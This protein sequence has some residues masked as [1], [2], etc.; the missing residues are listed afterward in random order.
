MSINWWTETQNM[1]YPYDGILFTREKE[2]ST[3]M[4]HN[5]DEPRKRAKWKK[6]IAKGHLSP[7]YIR[8]NCPGQAN[9][10]TRKINEWLPR[11]GGK[12]EE[13]GGNVEWLEVGTVS[14][15]GR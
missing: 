11:A 9:P 5:V 13:V 7:D 8:V 6:P 4:C 10:R 14:F 3:D 2:W 12:E 15:G 1:L